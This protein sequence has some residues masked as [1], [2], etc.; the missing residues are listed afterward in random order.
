MKREQKDKI[1]NVLTEGIND[2]TR[3]RQRQIAEER[4][5]IMGAESMLRRV[6]DVLNAE[7]EPQES[8]EP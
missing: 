5:K 1:L 4:G 7:V 8:E 6:F 3:E 2:Y